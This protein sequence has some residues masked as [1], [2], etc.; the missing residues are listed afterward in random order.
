MR[1][2]PSAAIIAALSFTSSAS[3]ASAWSFQDATLSVQGK[4]AGVGGGAKEKLAP[5]APLAT[6]LTLASTDTLKII[7]SATE[8]RTAKR[9]HQ[10][11]LTFH[12]PTT[13]LEE[14]FPLSL[15]ENGKGKVEVTQKDLP[16]QFL[17]STRPLKA[18]LV[19]ASFGSSTPYSHHAFDLTISPDPTTAPTAPTPPDRYTP[20]PTIHHTFKPDPQSPPKIL[21]LV[22]TLAIAATLPLLFAAWLLL[23]GNLDHAGKALGATPVAHA[24][25]FGSIVAMEGVFFLYYT[26]WNLFQTLPVAAVVGA[27]AYVSGSRALT[28]VQE[29][30]L[31]GER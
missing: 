1:I 30:R 5:N 16:Y 12:E 22:F 9:P 21:S 7:L 24:L 3:A 6:P 25:F 23:G 4:G 2:L 26:A 31:A 11:F 14:S 29:R 27:V 17:T 18:T 8:G 10:A 28:E 15:K 20:K 19:L 13:G